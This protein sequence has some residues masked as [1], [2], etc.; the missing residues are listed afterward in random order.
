M[1][2]HQ[3]ATIGDTVF[4]WFGANDTSG[5]GGDGATPLFDVREA[6][7]AA[8][9]APLISGTPTLLTEAS[10]PAGCFEVA[11]IATIGNGFA[12]D[13]T[14]GVF[15]TLAIDSQNPTGF[16]GSCTLTPLAKEGALQTVDDNV[17]SIL[18]DTAEIG[19]AGAGLTN[20]DLPNQT[21]DIIGSLSGSVGSVSADVTTDSASR[22]ASQADV[23]ALA[24][25]ASLDSAKGAGFVT[26]TD[27]LEAIR[28]RGDA[29]WTTG[30]GGSAPTV[31]EIADA[32]WDEAISGHTTGTSFGGKNQKVVP[33]ETVNDYKAD[34]SGLAT[35]T[36][37]TAGTIT[38]V[39]TNTDMRGTDGAN[40]V[41]PD[42]A[43]VVPTAIENRQE[44]DSNSTRLAAIEADTTGINGDDM[45]G[46]DGANTVTPD[47][48]GTAPTTS[49][50]AD[51]VLDA[52]LSDLADN[53]LNIGNS[54]TLRIV[55]R[56]LFNRFYRNVTQTAT[57]Q[58]V[59]NDSSGNVAVMATSDDTVTQTKGPAT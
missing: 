25:T 53:D 36:N 56:A 7:A 55:A 44:M 29:A 13:D 27:S 14:F 2:G 59:Q 42:A 52:V 22:T 39:T 30:A 24:T 4:F 34:V 48:A 15:A 12:A 58:T 45:R 9:A 49:E 18:L 32:V 3:T 26:G 31:D 43:G 47:P 35:P 19:I 41:V 23:S 5:S 50:I 37:I 20:I 10:Y 38:T 51:A 46:T 28:D 21:M 11:V 54:M 40:T 17:D 8:G 16:I 1:S 6:G 57:Q 33:S